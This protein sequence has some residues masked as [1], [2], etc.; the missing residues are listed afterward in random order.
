M[1]MGFCMSRSGT[2]SAL[3]RMAR[4]FGVV[5]VLLL[6]GCERVAHSWYL[7]KCDRAIADSTHA[8]ETARDDAQRATAYAQRG[9]NYSE[10]ARYSRVFKLIDTDEF[11]RLFSLAVSDHD[12]AVLLAPGNAEAYFGRGQTYFDRASVEKPKDAKRWF[13]RA[14]A[15]FRQAVERDPRNSM[16]LDMLGVVHVDTGEL[17]EAIKDFTEEM[18]LNP[19]GKA[20]LVD[21][22]CNRGSMNYGAKRYDAAIADYEKSIEMGT[23][24]DDCAC[25]PYNPL[26]TLYHL[27]RQYDKGWDTVHKAQHAKKWIDPE[28]LKKL[29]KDSPQ[30]K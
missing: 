4:L 15:D 29:E 2:R 18:A 22:Y 10:K 9:R 3:L 12:R 19:L 8:I 21:A 6:G 13:E 24:N 16:A 30:Q 23:T 1:L 28:I 20:R 5:A 17:D 14:A 11:G 25:D 27:G 7:S 26:I